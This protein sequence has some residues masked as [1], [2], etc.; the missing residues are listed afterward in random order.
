MGLTPLS[1]GGIILAR[2]GETGVFEDGHAFDRQL[3]KK[4]ANNIIR[5]VSSRKNVTR[6]GA[7][8]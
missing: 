5:S 3:R 4:L 1:E 8:R 7:V 2:L 6:G